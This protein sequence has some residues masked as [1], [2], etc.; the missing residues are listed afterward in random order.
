MKDSTIM[1]AQATIEHKNATS[2]LTQ[3]D[4]DELIKQTKVHSQ[5]YF[6][7][8]NTDHSVHVPNWMQRNKSLNWNDMRLLSL[9]LL[10]ISNLKRPMKA[11]TDEL[12]EVLYVSERTIYRSLKRLEDLNLVLRIRMR[13]KNM[14]GRFLVPN[15]EQVKLLME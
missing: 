5:F 11:F 12:A 1:P 13:F 4:L 15:M 7:N 10:N 9:L 14:K 8:I 6:D 2:P 3:V